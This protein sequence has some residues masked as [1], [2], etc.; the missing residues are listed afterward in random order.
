MMSI[1]TSQILKLKLI[2]LH[3]EKKQILLRGFLIEITLLWS[4]KSVKLK[5]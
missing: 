1:N 3:M 2:N 5:S 4:Y